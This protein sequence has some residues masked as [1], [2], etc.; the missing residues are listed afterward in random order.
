[1][2]VIS[3]SICLNTCVKKHDG[4]ISVQEYVIFSYPQLVVDDN[5]FFSQ[6]RTILLVSWMAATFP[7]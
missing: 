7:C 4:K 6:F 5:S 2:Y 3:C 1:M